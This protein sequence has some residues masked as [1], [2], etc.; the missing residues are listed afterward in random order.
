MDW[1]DYFLRLESAMPVL[2]AYAAELEKA[3]EDYLKQPETDRLL[4]LM[5]R[6]RT[7]EGVSLC[8]TRGVMQKALNTLEIVELEERKGC[9][10]FLCGVSAMEMAADRYRKLV[11]MLRRLELTA[12]DD[13]RMEA[14]RW[15]LQNGISPIA[16]SYVLQRE[17]FGNA[18]WI[19]DYLKEVYQIAGE[20]QV[21]DGC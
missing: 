20:R 11:M 7:T 19:H 10:V 13:D 17:I 3:F 1:D 8:N 15:L 6:F 16:I 4:Q 21:S 5:Q 14:I 12:E 9:S 2:T 18:S